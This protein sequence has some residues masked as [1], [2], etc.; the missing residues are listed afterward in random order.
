MGNPFKDD[1]A[2]LLAVDSYNCAN[3]SVISTVNTIKAIGTAKYQKYVSDVLQLNLFQFI[4][5]LKKNSLPLWKGS[6][7]KLLLGP[8]KN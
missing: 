8:P 4:S 2:E 3:E 5:L 7:P 1:C 6:L